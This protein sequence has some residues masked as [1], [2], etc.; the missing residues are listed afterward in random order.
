MSERRQPSRV[1]RT[2]AASTGGCRLG[3][4]VASEPVEVQVTPR[5]FLKSQVEWAL[6]HGSGRDHGLRRP[7]ARHRQGAQEVADSGM[8]VS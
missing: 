5:P 4:A 8:E 7:S 3:M 1:A 2:P 6:S